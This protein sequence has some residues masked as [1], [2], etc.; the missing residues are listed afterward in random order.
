MTACGKELRIKVYNEDGTPLSDANVVVRYVGSGPPIVNDGKSDENGVFMSH[1]KEAAYYIELFVDKEGYYTS[2]FRHQYATA[3]R[4]NAEGDFKVTLRKKG[5]ASPL[6]AKR[7]HLLLPSLNKKYGFDFEKGDWVSPHGNGAIADLFF[8]A[9]KKV[10]DMSNYRAVLTCEFTTNDDGI[11]VDSTWIPGSTY[12]QMK[13]IDPK[14]KFANRLKIVREQKGAKGGFNT[15]LHNYVFRVRTITDT[16]GVIK[17]A[18]YG[19][20]LGGIDA[21]PATAEPDAFAVDFVYF[22][23]AKPNDLNLEFDRKLNL[24][25]NLTNDEHVSESIPRIGPRK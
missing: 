3:L 5:E 12:Q 18:N 17:S 13:Q 22:Y 24:F 23:N 16:Q 2:K 4:K 21:L 7:V 11:A 25:K 14:G 20:F 1:G 19:R 15:P 9:E 8:H 6:Y 10:V